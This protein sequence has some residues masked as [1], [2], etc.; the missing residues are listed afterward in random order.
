MI[1]SMY[2][3]H[4][5]LVDPPGSEG[6]WVPYSPQCG[7]TRPAAAAIMVDDHPN[8]DAAVTKRIALTTTPSLA[9][10]HGDVWRLSC[11]SG[12]GAARRLVAQ[13]T[14][15]QQGIAGVVAADTVRCRRG[16]A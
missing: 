16:A 10:G 9:G 11:V 3:L 1:D 6:G 8:D 15:R 12:S 5:C 14:A 2:A 13:D 7:R 4:A